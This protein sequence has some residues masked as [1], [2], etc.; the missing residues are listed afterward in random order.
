[1]INSLSLCLIVMMLS[2]FENVIQGVFFSCK[3]AEV[4]T[5][6]C[7]YPSKLASKNIHIFD[8]STNIIYI[9]R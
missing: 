6:D 1:M 7:R 4:Q 9:S 8:P 3:I 2:N 5:I